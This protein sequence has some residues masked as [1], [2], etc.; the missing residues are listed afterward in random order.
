MNEEYDLL[1]F[2]WF[3]DIEQ[4]DIK[5]LN[6]NVNNLF[7]NAIRLSDIL[8]PFIKSV[9]KQDMIDNNWAIIQKIN[10]GGKLFLRDVREN[11]T[12]K[13]NL[14]LVEADTIIYSKIN[15][16]HG[17]IYYHPKESIPFGVSS[18]YPCFK[19]DS[20][21]VNGEYIV[22]V[23][24]SDY[25]KNLLNAK[26]VGISKARVKR[27]EFESMFIPLPSL[28]EQERLIGQYNAIVRDADLLIEKAKSLEIS[29]NNYIDSIL[30][31]EY[32]SNDNEIEIDGMLQFVE[33]E[34][35]EEWGVDKMTTTQIHTSKYNKLKVKDICKLSS[36]GTP[37]RTNPSYYQGDIPWIKTGEVVNEV[38]VDTE[39]HISKEAVKNSSARLYPKGSLIIA[40]YGQGD[41]RGRTAKLGIDATTNQACAVMYNI[42]NS[43][44]DT[45]YLWYYFQS[46]Y[47]DL[48]SLAVGNNQPNLNAGMILNYDVVIPPMPVQLEIVSYISKKKNEIKELKSQAVT[49]RAKALE[50]FEKE[51]FD[52]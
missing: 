41:T 22:K 28:S 47:N 43:I 20:S 25:F 44:I 10:F 33:F 7:S 16:R 30:G 3:E 40:M 38:I 5:R 18:E 11:N 26:S 4:W 21:K 46:R 1:N 42:D 19:F 14:N 39:E 45:D 52:N 15:V 36:G 35:L 8:Q 24:R 13:G 6:W 2:V 49:L 50:D 32:K 17:C 29:L 51:I 31:I 23:I 34:K 27:D 48:R 12:F 9:S 37:S